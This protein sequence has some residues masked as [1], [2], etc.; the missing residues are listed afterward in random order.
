MITIIVDTYG[1]YRE[2]K[3]R[4][5]NYVCRQLTMKKCFS[6]NHDCDKCYKDNHIKAGIRVIRP[7]IIP[8]DSMGKDAL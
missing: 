8:L 3:E 6:Y 5:Q 7:A 2:M 4:A 1:E